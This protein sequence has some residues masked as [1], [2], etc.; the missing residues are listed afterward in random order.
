MRK[1]SKMWR[2]LGASPY[3][4]RNLGAGLG[5]P[6]KETMQARLDHPNRLLHWQTPTRVS[7]PD[8]RDPFVMRRPDTY[9]YASNLVSLERRHQLL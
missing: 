4:Q 7:T 3:S 5:I 1:G 6:E 8:M 9:G 2:T